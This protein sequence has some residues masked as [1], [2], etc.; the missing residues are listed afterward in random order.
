M[1]GLLLTLTNCAS[2]HDPK[3]KFYLVATNIKVAYWQTAANGFVRAANQMKVKAEVVGPDTY[4]PKAEQQEFERVA[5]LKPSGILIS[6]A[7]ENLLK[8]D[9]DA[10]I[11]SGVPVITMD[12]DSPTS[13]RVLFI[14]TNNYEAGLLGGRT[15]VKQMDGHGRIVIL[16]MP[17]Q[18]NLDERL[19]GYRDAFADHKGME[20]VRVVDI[21]GDP[22]IAF[23]TTTDIVNKKE[24]V[25][26][27]VCLE[28]LA[29][30]EVAEVLDR[31][32]VTGKTIIAMDTDEGTLNWV[33][34]G[35][36]AATI[37]QKPFTMSYFGVQMLD[38]IFHNK[39]KLDNNWAQDPF[40]LVPVF[41]DTGLTLVDKSNV[42]AFI[43][44]RE[45]SKS[46]T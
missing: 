17:G 36:I 23:D 1:G 32:H 31:N 30:K 45:S 25:D 28:A 9:I 24:K 44:A 10:A 13:K 3:E 42:D 38:H 19:H 12:S 11:E 34:K 16:T 7:D 21:K 46:E 26:G 39:L 41:I 29:G 4:D 2:Q 22:R 8:G 6:V 5:K 27:F 14:G 33:Q 35:A 20:I 40:S 15:A 37:A 18:H 43:K